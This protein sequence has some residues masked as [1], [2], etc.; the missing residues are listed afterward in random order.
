MKMEDSI[1]YLKDFIEGRIEAVGEG[2]Q[3][4]NRMKC[5]HQ[6]QIDAFE[7]VLEM[8]EELGDE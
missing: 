1:A 8:I 5:F 3:E 4:D 6:G 2:P 7:E